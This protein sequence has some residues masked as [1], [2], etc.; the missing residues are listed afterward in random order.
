MG[1]TNFQVTKDI[2]F[3][4]QDTIL[5]SSNKINARLNALRFKDAETNQV[6]YYLPSLDISGYGEDADKAMELAKFSVQEYFGYLLRL[7]QKKRE[8][9]LRELGWKHNKLRH[10]E[11]SKAFVDDQGELQNFAIEG[12]VER[13]TLVA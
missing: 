8:E 7:S 9:E 11:Y 6:V 2:N 12:K 4:D 5:I 1:L 13:L 3:A 10:K